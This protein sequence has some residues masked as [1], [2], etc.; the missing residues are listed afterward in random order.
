MRHEKREK[1]REK[2]VWKTYLLTIAIF[3]MLLTGLTASASCHNLGGQ[4]FDNPIQ[5]CSFKDLVLT[6]SR[7]IRDVA[8]PVAVVSIIYVGFKMVLGA[9]SGNQGEIASA[10][11][12]L[13]YVLLGTALV[14]GSSVLAKAVVD[15]VQTLR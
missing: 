5:A 4:F 11:K 6:I 15:F 1:S 14:V 8:I 10:R 12:M 9:A 13:M 2:N 3:V 7:A